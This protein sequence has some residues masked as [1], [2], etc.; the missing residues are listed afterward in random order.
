MNESIPTGRIKRSISSGR[1]ITRLGKNQLGYYLKRPFLSREKKTQLTQKK[2][3][4]NAKIIFDGLTLLRGTALKAAQML[5]FENDLIPQEIRRELEKSYH[6][7]PPINRALARKIITANLGSA[8]EALFRTFDSAAFAAASLG[9]V[10]RAVTNE[11]DVLAV[12]IQYPD[13]AGTISGDIRLLKGVLRP[14]PEYEIIK[15]A[16]NEI[17]SVLLDETDYEKE[18]QNI[19]FF[20][21]N[22]KLDQVEVPHLFSH[23]SSR[24]VLAM[25]H[26]KGVTLNQWLA[27]E[28]QQQDK[29]RVAQMMHDIFVKGFYQLKTIHAD[30]NPGNYLV[31]SDNRLGLIDFGCIK[32]FDDRFINIYQ[33]LIKIGARNDRKKCLDLLERICLITP[34]IDPDIS[35]QL[36][37]LFMSMGEWVGQLFKDE[38]FD[39]GAH[40]DF[41]KQGRQIGMQ[42]HKFRKHIH[43]I[44]PEFIFLDRTRY[45]LI[46]MFEKM[47]VKIRLRSR[48]ENGDR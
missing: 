43:S 37:D 30:P 48:F 27:Q 9:Q 5:S 31:M 40:P 23:Y 39:F 3:R 13:I 22:L 1:I 33:D 28:P 46:R 47:K 36:I 25:G 41:M 12:K 8:P 38:F 44:T 26:M 19:R 42:M 24:H 7:V 16:L 29:N 45:G 17:E 21:D 34:D 10:H 18:A 2:D 15:T 35:E 20:K 4:D 11:G 32:R 6:Q 14:L